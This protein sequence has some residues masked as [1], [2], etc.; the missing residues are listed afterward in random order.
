MAHCPDAVT[1]AKTDIKDVPGGVEVTVTGKD[2]AAT[3]DIRARV[4]ALVDAQK[5]QSPNVKH[6]GTGE[7]GGLLGRCPIVLKDTTI[8]TADVEGGSK[9]TVAAKDADEVDWLRRETRDRQEDL[10][11][12][13]SPAGAGK[14]AHCP[15][16]IAGVTTTLKNTKEGVT[17][18][19]TGTDDATTKS[20][21][22]RVEHLVEIAKSPDA[23]EGAPSHTGEGGGGGGIGRCPV[24][25]QDTKLLAKDIPGGS[26]VD[27]KAKSAAE[28]GK[29]QAEAKER[30]AKFQLPDGGTRGS[31]SGSASPR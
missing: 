27:M 11:A 9:M 24:V 26:Q 4:Q 31:A 10:E 21:R 14:M 25:V 8:T 20:I 16:A 30:A 7:G 29:L 13:G 12:A 17:V 23:G 28:V 3:S 2:P 22:E 15:S 18:T 5:N 6:T 1:G 19:L